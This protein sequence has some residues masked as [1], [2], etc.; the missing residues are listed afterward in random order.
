MIEE[1][2]LARDDGLADAQNGVLSLLDVF[3]QLDG[4]GKSFFDVISNVAVRGVFDE[5]PAVGGAQPQ[6]R[7]VVFI[8]ERLP[9]VIHL[10][11]VH[12]RLDEPRLRLVVAQTGT[13]IELLDHFE[14]ALDDFQRAVQGARNFFQLVGLHLLQMFGDDLL[15][16]CV[17]R[18][19]GLQ[20]E[21]QA[22]AQVPR[23]HANGIEVLHH[24]QGIVQIV[25]RILSAL[26]QF[27]G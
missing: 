27:F 16:Q 9:L 3:H 2:A 10:P 15:G 21:E 26:R 7:Q 22:L 18:I 14:R 17:L 20:L 23:A 4:S 8:Q 13:R 19:E 1:L 25:L 6:L 12:I 11:E 24:G 5:Q